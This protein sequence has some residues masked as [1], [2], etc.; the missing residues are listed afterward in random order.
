MDLK[1]ID[2]TVVKRYTSPQAIK[3]LDRFL[4][5]VPMTVGY[6]AL[7]TAGLVWLLAAGA[8]FFTSLET[9]KVSKMHTDLL[10]I[11]ALRPPIPVLQ[12]IPVNQ[13][14]LKNLS[15]KITSTY[16]G[17]SIV[18]SDGLATLTAADTDYFPQF[19]AAVSYLQ[20]GGR[21]WKVKIDTFCVGRGCTGSKLTANLKIETV[22]FGEPEVQKEG[23]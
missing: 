14:V 7:I 5:S 9:E 2:W 17:I 16:K 19:L 3:D 4:D 12:Y 21:N 23:G 13:L 6:N 20:R 1:K 11:Q 15:E 18:T 8:I 10:Q 22:R